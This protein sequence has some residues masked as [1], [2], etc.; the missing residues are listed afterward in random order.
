MS[1]CQK[2]G[3]ELPEGV[4]CDCENTQTPVAPETP[5]V[6]PASGNAPVN[7]G[8]SVTLPADNDNDD[9]EYL[10]AIKSCKILN[11]LAIILFVGGVVSLLLVNGWVAAI[12]FFVAEISV[13]IPNTGVQKLCKAKNPTADKKAMQ[14]AVKETTKR[15]KAKDKNFNFSF[16]IAI[17]CL[18]SL[19][20]SF[21]VPSP[22]LGS[23]NN[24]ADNNDYSSDDYEDVAVNGNVQGESDISDE[25][26][27]KVEAVSF[28][29]RSNFEIYEAIKPY[30]KQ[31]GYDVDSWI[32]D[33]NT[34]DCLLLFGP[35]YSTEGQM[36]MVSDNSSFV[37]QMRKNF[38]V[39]GDG[40]DGL[41]IITGRGSEEEYIFGFVDALLS[42]C[43]EELKYTGQYLRDN[44][45]ANAN[46]GTARFEK[47]GIEYEITYLPNTNGWHILLRLA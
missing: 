15:L 34:K 32:V 3:K 9:D 18:I 8:A 1:F 10:V 44:Y 36:V 22:L 40:N 27:E 6:V 26:D 28:I 17:I 14:R 12:M 38:F 39:T 41:F 29:T 25:R 23:N 37:V 5:F 19:I 13:L 20:A 7:E 45:N 47:E 46:K 11:I 43:P 4:A 31:I 2:C 35:E 16:I 42:E 24:S 21:I 33:T 30:C